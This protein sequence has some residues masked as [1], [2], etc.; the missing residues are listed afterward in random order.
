M[1]NL[2]DV[3]VRLRAPDGCDWDKQQDKKQVVRYLLE[4]LY[5]LIDAV[6][7]DD[8]TNEQEEAGDVFFLL[9]FL[10]YIAAERNEYHLDSV[11]AQAT[12]KMIRRHPHIFANAE[13]H[14]LSEIKA[15]WLA[16]KQQEKNKVPSCSLE[17]PP[18]SMPQL[19]RAQKVQYK[20]SQL[21][22]DWENIEGV[23]QKMGEE[24]DELR[25]ALTNTQSNNR[26]E[27]VGDI[28]FTAVNIA[29][30]LDID[31]EK[32]LRGSTEKFTQRFSQMEAEIKASGK[33]LAAIRQE[34]WNRAWEN[35][36]RKR[37]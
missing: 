34:E 13:V 7:N 33:T 1:K 25:D 22:F 29:R 23:L 9:L 18:R 26:E 27:E 11:I 10:I 12:E 31:A 28:L 24:L 19:L 36:K 20:A 30:F 5:E 3:I 2:M 8:I 35:I 6:E 4:E 15:N 21:G 37:E 32:A 14:G 17:P 16:I